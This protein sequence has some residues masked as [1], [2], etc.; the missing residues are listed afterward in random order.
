MSTGS[1]GRRPGRSDTRRQILDAARTLFAANGVRG[2]SLRAVAAAAGVSHAMIRHHF[3]TKEALFLATVQFPLDPDAIVAEIVRNGPRSAVG[4]RAA[5]LF[6]AAWR[7]PD[8]GPALQTLLR[9]ATSDPAGAAL[10][11]RMIEDVALPRVSAALDVPRE[12]LATA[13][14]QLLGLALLTSVLQVEPL[15]SASDEALVAL[16]APWL[17]D[18]LRP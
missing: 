4:E 18:L 8:T 1:A 14:A 10:V 15:A 12:R 11:R 9:N 6:V 13:M 17:Q 5:R 16:V 2:T 3:G 7:A